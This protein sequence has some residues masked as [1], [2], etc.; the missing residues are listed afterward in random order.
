[1]V[2]IG[3]AF[4]GFELDVE[5][6][7]DAWDAVSSGWLPESGYQPADG[8]CCEQYHNDANEHPAHK[9]DVSICVPVKPPQILRGAG[10]TAASPNTL[11]VG[12]R[13]IAGYIQRYTRSSPGG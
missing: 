6:Y 3:F 2:Y 13:R 11:G 4:A 1:M 9:C 7:G 10:R 5:Q 12:K 8:I